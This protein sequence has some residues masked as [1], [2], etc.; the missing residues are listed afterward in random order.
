MVHV[1]ASEEHPVETGCGA[2]PGTPGYSVAF[3]PLDGSSVI[4]ANFAVGTIAGVWPGPGLLGRT[5][6]EQAAALI[7]QYGPRV[8]VAL[9]LS[10]ATA[11]AGAPA[12]LELTMTESGWRVTVDQ[13]VIAP[14]AKTFA[15]GNLRA[16]SDNLAYSRLVQYWI[17]NRY[18]PSA[19]PATFPKFGSGVTVAR[20][21]ASA[22]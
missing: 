4:G 7:A 19:A 9:A 6:A 14:S 20:L 21:V 16:A 11:A 18:I 22:R 10:K 13:F 5:G 17:A 3:D 8:T 15:P 12:C 1:A 2:P